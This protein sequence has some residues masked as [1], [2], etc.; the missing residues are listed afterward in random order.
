MTHPSA[1]S[2]FVNS[3]VKIKNKKLLEKFPELVEYNKQGTIPAGYLIAN[4]GLSGKKIGKAKISEKHSNFIINLGGAKA[5]DVLGLIKLAKE[6]VKNNFGINL[7][8]EV[9][10]VGFPKK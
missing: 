2:T 6:K 7:E 10:L 9:Q 8:A 3:E 5:K 1:A 4:S